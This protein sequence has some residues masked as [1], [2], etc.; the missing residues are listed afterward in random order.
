MTTF[1]QV[2]QYHYKI[3][4]THKERMTT[5]KLLNEKDWQPDH[6]AHI[7][8]FKQCKQEFNWF[9]RKHHCRG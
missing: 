3:D 4:I 2:Y 1:N 9:Q 5:F 7:C 6:Q 8:S